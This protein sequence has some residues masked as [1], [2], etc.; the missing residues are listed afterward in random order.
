MPTE[1]ASFRKTFELLKRHVVRG[2]PRR[3]VV[4]REL[5]AFEPWEERMLNNTALTVTRGY[6]STMT[7]RE[8]VRAYLY[9]LYLHDD[10]G[11][12]KT[13]AEF[14]PYDEA[15][16]EEFL[17]RDDGARSRLLRRAQRGEAD[18]Q[19]AATGSSPARTTAL[20]LRPPLGTRER[21]LSQ[22]PCADLLCCV[23]DG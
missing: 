10:T 18:P 3:A 21:P 9:G 1:A 4:L 19:R 11:L 6:R 17:T 15:L 23:H 13:L 5:A 2:S 7:V 12:G 8:I 20:A 16:R 14:E 22:R